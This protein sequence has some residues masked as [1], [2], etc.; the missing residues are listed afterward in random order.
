MSNL[1]KYLYAGNTNIPIYLKR[2]NVHFI[3]NPYLPDNVEWDRLT[4]IIYEIGDYRTAID[5]LI[6]NK[7]PVIILQSSLQVLLV[8]AWQV[9]YQLDI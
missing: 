6:K 2:K 3:D 9:H 1:P 8:Q 7:R 4:K 5:W